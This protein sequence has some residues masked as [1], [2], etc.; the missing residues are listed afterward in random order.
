MVAGAKTRARTPSERTYTEIWD[1]IARS[2]FPPG[3][4]LVERDLSDRYGHSRTV[5]REAL[6]RLEHEGIVERIPNRGAFVRKLTPREI[7]N[8]FSARE[9][10]E[11]MAAR[12]AASRRPDDG[13]AQVEAELLRVRPNVDAVSIGEFAKVGPQLHDR[14]VEWSANRSLQRAYAVLRSEAMLVRSLTQREAFFQ[15]SPPLI[16][17][18]ESASYEDHL[19]VVS[20]L[21][22]RDGEAAEKAMRSHLVKTCRRIVQELVGVDLSGEV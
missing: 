4:L 7:V 14:I 22:A 2:V 20:A 17:K 8:I 10:V 5:V 16:L 1:A 3:A 18:I 12:L 11:G 9:A 13:V 15:A 6:F 19:T 21:K